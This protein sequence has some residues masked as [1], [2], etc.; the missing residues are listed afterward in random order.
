MSIVW[1]NLVQM[2]TSSKPQ[3]GPITVLCPIPSREL[4]PLLRK[5]PL[6]YVYKR[7]STGSAEHSFT[8]TAQLHFLLVIHLYCILKFLSMER[9]KLIS[10][11]FSFCS[12]WLSRSWDSQDLLLESKIERLHLEIN[13]LVLCFGSMLVLGGLVQE[14]FDLTSAFCA[15]VRIEKFLGHFACH[16]N[17]FK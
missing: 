11:F 15:C 16:F 4:W 9:A 2:K 17:G 8:Y 14:M 13:T 3:R 5:V 6:A 10:F 12:D 7:H 1:D